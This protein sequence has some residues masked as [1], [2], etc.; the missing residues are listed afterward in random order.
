MTVTVFG[1]LQSVAVNVTDAGATVPSVVS[2]LASVT[3]TFA[4]G[5]DVSTML[6]R[7]GPA[8]LRS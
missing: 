2:L 1:V 8:R 7:R 3:V 6:E 4:V 5:C